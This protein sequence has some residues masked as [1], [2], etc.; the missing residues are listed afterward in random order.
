M[1]KN[2]YLIWI[3]IGLIGAFVLGMMGYELILSMIKYSYMRPIFESDFIGLDNYAYLFNY[4]L[5]GPA[6]VNAIVQSLLSILPALVLGVGF[7][8]LLG[9]IPNK[10]V[11]AAFAG[12]ALLLALVPTI[13]WEQLMAGLVTSITG[14]GLID[15]NSAE[16]TAVLTNLIPTI[17]LSVFAGL[18]LSISNDAPAWKAALAASLVPAML[19]FLPDL[20]TTYLITNAVNMRDVQTTTYLN[21][22]L[23][24][25]NLQLSRSSALS[26]MCR[27]LSMVLGALPAML[28]GWAGGRAPSLPR[29]REEGSGWVFG[30]LAALVVAA[31]AMAVMLLVTASSGMTFS[32]QIGRSALNTALAALITLPIAFLFCLLVISLSRQNRSVIAF[33]LLSL[34]LI[35]LS[36]FA[37]TGYMLLQWLGMMNTFFGLAFSS[38]TNPVFLTVLM[39][40]AAQRPVTWRQTFFLA[41]GGAF[42]AAACCAGDFL[43]A[44]LTIHDNSLR[45]LALQLLATANTSASGAARTELTAALASIRF[46]LTLITLAIALPGVALVMGGVGGSRACKPGEEADSSAAKAEPDNPLGL[47]RVSLAKFILLSIVTLGIYQWVCVYRMM[48]SCRNIAGKEPSC[49]G[50]FLLYLF[51]P[52]YSLYWIFTRSQTFASCANAKGYCMVSDHSA[53]YLILSIFGLSWLALLLMQNDINLVADASAASAANA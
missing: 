53:V 19:M 50:E 5:F 14:T 52:F 34:F 38:L 28:M 20:R 46:L 10:A 35:L 41:F 7:A 40:L 51:V 18:T 49:A 4:R 26:V 48:K 8:F 37:V 11:K 9:L 45:P 27:G 15:K 30:M 31:L 24:I 43:P 6:L 3:P 36:T 16:Y 47:Y 13:V 25:M 33:G 1:Q 44:L 12:G 39:L 32:D 42:V 22:Q 2:R 23:G 17:S 29:R 21:Y